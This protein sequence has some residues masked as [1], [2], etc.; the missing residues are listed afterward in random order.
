MK[1]NMRQGQNPQMPMLKFIRTDL[2]DTEKS[3]LK[4]I[5]DTMKSDMDIVMSDSSNSD[6][7][8]KTICDDLFS[9]YIDH[10]TPYVD[11]TKI[12]EFKKSMTETHNSM[13]NN[14][15][16]AGGEMRDAKSDIG[17]TNLPKVVQEVKT[18]VKQQFKLLSAKTIDMLDSKIDPIAA[19]KKE[20]FLNK[21]IS[22]VQVMVDSSTGKKKDILSELATYL[23]NKLDAITVVD[24]T[25]LLNEIIQ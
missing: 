8:K 5:T 24:D 18:E 6:A 25:S 12:D 9:K 7:D 16:K 20:A 22:K 4:Q 17:K 13:M 11:S 1:D 21:I 2:T 19:D 23:Q 3:E 10:I 15:H 14:K